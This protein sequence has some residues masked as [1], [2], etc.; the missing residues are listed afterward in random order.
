MGGIPYCSAWRKKKK[1]ALLSAQHSI[2]THTH[3]D[4][5]EYLNHPGT[6][7]Y[8]PSEPPPTTTMEQ[9]M[10]HLSMRKWM[11]PWHMLKE[12]VG[13]CVSVCNRRPNAALGPAR[14]GIRHLLLGCATFSPDANAEQASCCVISKV[15]TASLAA[16]ATK[17]GSQT[18]RTPLQQIAVGFSSFHPD[19]RLLLPQRFNLAAFNDG[20]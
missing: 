6:Q 17:A 15:L 8:R 13:S 2:C 5:S 9:E 10:L 16:G 7:T 12:G 1:N 4:A 18:T 14:P 11:A 3:R 20:K 19:R